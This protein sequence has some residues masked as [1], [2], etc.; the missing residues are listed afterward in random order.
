M[1][2]LFKSM[3]VNLDE[4]NHSFIGRWLVGGSV[5]YYAHNIY[6]QAVHL[7][8]DTDVADFFGQAKAAF[9]VYLDDVLNDVNRV[10]E[11]ALS[12]DEDYMYEPPETDLF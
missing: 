7:D 10:V 12:D 8:S 3:H 5:V 11:A 2:V 4:Y 9:F 1:K 6:L